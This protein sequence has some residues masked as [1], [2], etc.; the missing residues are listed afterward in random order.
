MSSTTSTSTT[1]R[2]EALKGI[3][4]TV[5][6]GE[7]VTLI[8]ANGAGKTTTLKTISGVRPVAP[9]TITFDGEDITGMA[10]APARRARHLPGARGPGDLPGHDACIENLEMGALHPQGPQVGGQAADLD[11][12]LRRCS[13]GLPSA[14]RRRAARCPAASSRCSPSAGR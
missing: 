13:P 14:G 11:R 6:E 2:I 12:V 5:D 4:F 8:G 3:S 10:A 1:A 7:I 9:G